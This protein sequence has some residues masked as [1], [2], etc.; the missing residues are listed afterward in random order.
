MSDTEPL[1]SRPINRPIDRLLAEYGESHQ[2]E[3]NKAVHWICVPAI[4]WTVIALLWAIPSPFGVPFVNWATLL[5]A[6][7]SREVV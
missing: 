3:T 6:I 7:V 5:L 4:V 1:P 2:N